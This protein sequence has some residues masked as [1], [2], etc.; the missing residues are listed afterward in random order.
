MS[1]VPSF[2]AWLSLQHWGIEWVTNIGLYGKV[3]VLGN[4]IQIMLR[5]HF[6]RVGRRLYG[7]AAL[8]GRILRKAGT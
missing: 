4:A 2:L 3:I 8:T 7:I 1:Q 5:Q 6:L